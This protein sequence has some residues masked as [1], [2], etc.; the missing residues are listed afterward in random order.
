LARLRNRDAWRG[1][2]RSYPADLREEADAALAL[3]GLAGRSDTRADRLSGGE[4]QKVSLARLL[5]QRPSLILADEPTSALDPMAVSQVCSVLRDA[6]AGG[7]LVTVVHH[8]NLLPAMATRV[9][10]LAGGRM[11]WDLPLEAV[12]DTRLDALYRLSGAATTEPVCMAP[13]GRAAWSAA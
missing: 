3:L 9:I 11:A 10:G 2:L 13:A 1:W 8:R 12:D 5:L 4:R 6:A 7:T